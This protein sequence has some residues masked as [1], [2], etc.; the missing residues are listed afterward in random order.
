KSAVTANLGFAMPINA[1]KPLL[2]KPNPIAMQHWLTL[3]A[4]DPDEWE[5]LFEAR[6]R[7]RAGR[8][9]VEGLGKGFGGRSLCL[10]KR[11]VPEQPYEV[12]VTVRLDDEAGAAG[13]VFGADGSDKHYGFYPSAGN[14][15]LTRF[16][17]PD[18]YSWKVIEQKPSSHYRPGD[19]NTL[20]VRLEKDKIKCYVNDHLVTELADPKFPGLRVGLAKFRETR[21]E[22]KQFQTA[23]QIAAKK[24]SP[25]LAK[26]IAK[27]L[28]GLPAGASSKPEVMEPLLSGGAASVTALRD[29]AQQLEQ[30]AA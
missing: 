13:L 17:G 12:A 7:Q 21:A 30:Q 29:R 16:D 26:R 6:W 24:L 9:Q 15:R 1:L 5:P 14:L 25:D 27:S 19:W 2:K 23:K 18:V 28:D 20:K 4:L 22:F 11:P 10:S 3:G 8:I